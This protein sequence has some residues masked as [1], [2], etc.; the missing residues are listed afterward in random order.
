MCKS[1][2]NSNTPSDYTIHYQM[3]Y[4]VFGVLL[5]TEVKSFITMENEMNVITFL[6]K[7]TIQIEDTSDRIIF[8]F[9]TK[10]MEG[11]TLFDNGGGLGK[12][13]AV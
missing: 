8:E 10:S 3:Y 4:Q 1:C 5:P 11:Y 12:K 13:T 9:P 6:I 7:P 2:S